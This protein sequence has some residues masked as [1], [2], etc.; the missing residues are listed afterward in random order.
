VV[1]LIGIPGPY[2]LALDRANW[3]VGSDDLNIL[4]LTIVYRGIGFPVVWIILPNAGNPDTSERETVIEIFIDLFGVRSIACLLDDRE[5][6]GREWFRFLKR[7]R[8][9]FQMRLHNGKRL[10][11]N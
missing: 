3:M 5:F 1:K 6:V 8:N 4:M 9:R 10:S 11:K 7:H 2:T